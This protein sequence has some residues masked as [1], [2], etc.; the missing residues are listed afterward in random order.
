MGILGCGVSVA[1]VKEVVLFGGGF[2][3]C[4]LDLTYHFA[5]SSFLPTSV[6]NVFGLVSRNNLFI[7]LI[8]VLCLCHVVQLMFDFLLTSSEYCVS[9]CLTVCFDFLALVGNSFQIALRH[10]EEI[11]AQRHLI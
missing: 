3:P 11:D 9:I 7:Q 1:E 4:C 6:V 8:Q 10:S 5:K 2:L